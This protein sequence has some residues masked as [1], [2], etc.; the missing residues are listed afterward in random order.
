MQTLHSFAIHRHLHLHNTNF[1][2][3]ANNVSEQSCTVTL[4]T[5]V[6]RTFSSSED[7]FAENHNLN[8][9]QLKMDLH[10]KSMQGLN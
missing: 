8:I 5:H 9:V 10:F 7:M 6:I 1:E 4:V 2:T 3:P